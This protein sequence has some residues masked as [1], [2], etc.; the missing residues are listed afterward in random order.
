ML[1]EDG[2]R[3]VLGAGV[4]PAVALTDKDRLGWELVRAEGALKEAQAENIR[5]AEENLRLGRELEKART[6]VGEMRGLMTAAV[7]AGAELVKVAGSMW[8]SM[9]HAAL[10]LGI[11]PD[12]GMGEGARP[13]GGPLPRRIPGALL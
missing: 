2:P 13:A 5:L 9:Q 4:R 3:E 11:E 6:E 12:G 1:S 10:R 7:S 8:G